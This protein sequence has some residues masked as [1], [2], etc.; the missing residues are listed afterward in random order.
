MRENRGIGSIMTGLLLVVCCSA[1]ATAAAQTPWFAAHLAGD[2]EV[3]S[4]GD[5]DGWGLGVVGVGAGTVTYYVWVTDISQPSMAHIHAAPAGQGGTVVVDFAATFTEVGPNTYVATGTVAAEPGTTGALLDN[6]A[7][8]YVNVHNADHPA[9][10]VRGQVLGDGP[11]RRAL[12]GT[13]R[14]FREVD[15]P[16]DPDGEGFGAV[17]FDDHTAHYFV[18]VNNIDNPAASHIHAGTAAQNGPIAIDFEAAFTDGIAV[19]SVPVGEDVESAVLAHPENYY[20]NVHN[21]EY[22][23]GAARGQLRATESLFI[24][25]VA[26]R[27]AGQA[28]SEWRTDLRVLNLSDEDASVWAEWY[29]SSAGGLTGPDATVSLGVGGSSTAVVNDSVGT[30]FGADGNGAMRLLAAEPVVAAS[31][32]FNDQR[33]NPEIGGTFG[34]Y[35]PASRP[36]ELL[37][38]GAL[39]LGANRPA[40]SGEGMRSNVGY[41]NPYPAEVAATFSVWS[42]DGRVL[43][44]NSLELAPFANEVRGVYQ[45]V[46]SV[47]QSERNRDDLV[48]TFSA[49]RP[50]AVYLSVVDNVTN[51]P[52]LISP[53]P[54]PAVLRESSGPPANRAPNGTI[55]QP[56]GNVTI[57]EGDSVVF[58]GS[59][60]DPDGDGMT[61]LWDFGDSITSTDLSPGPHTYTAAGTYTATF[62]V[63]DARGL[64]D[65]SPDT[66]TI[67]V[68]G[69]GAT[70]TQVQSQIFTASCALSGCHTGSSPA[71]GMNLSEGSAYSNIVNVPSNEQP[72]LDR[73]EPNDP[74]ASY[75]YLKVTGDPSI[76]GEQMPFGGPP[77]SQTLI[78]LLRNWIERG[79]PND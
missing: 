2:R 11:S 40:A 65:P 30:L 66:R 15:N 14:G 46:P 20:V 4:P 60:A 39:L 5:A 18:A 10:A 17:V 33:D 42:V 36:A 53:S 24:F 35:A 72:T 13:L 68:E 43:G 37:G 26:S 70:F 75:L 57:N 47:P 23:S 58:E 71:Q 8:F 48:V 64:A 28:G 78:D 74:A 7:G 12:A 38:A 9:G 67:V 61:Y 19:G 34:Q 59:A 62:T 1:A 51:D 69:G 3:D 32:I 73:I 56:S 50:I 63:T 29:P 25:S 52:V 76:V 22:P 6:P 55:L 45:L 21:S 77:L 44:T 27:I 16:G 79:A 49:A 41:F 54:A 31:R